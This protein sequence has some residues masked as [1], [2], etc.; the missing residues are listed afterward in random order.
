MP[1]F[2]AIGTLKEDWR[3]RDIDLVEREFAGDVP[4]YWHEN[5]IGIDSFSVDLKEKKTSSDDQGNYWARQEGNG[6]GSAKERRKKREQA[7]Q[8]AGARGVRKTEEVQEEQEQEKLEGYALRIAK[9]SDSVTTEIMN[10]AKNPEPKDI[11]IDCCTTEDNWQYLTLVFRGA[12]P[13]QSTLEDDP[14]DSIVFQW[15]SAIVCAWKFDDANEPIITNVVEFGDDEEVKDASTANQ[16]GLSEFEATPPDVNEGSASGN[17]ARSMYRALSGGLPPVVE[18]SRV[19]DQEHRVLQVDDIDGIE[20]HIESFRGEERISDLYLFDL[21]LRSDK[22]DVVPKD[23]IGKEVKWRLEDDEGI[24]SGEE[25]DPR[26]FHGVI[27]TLLVGELA[28]NTQRRYHVTVVPKVWL[29]TQR[30]D[31]RV[32]QAM[33]AKAI[34]EDVFSRTKFSDYDMAG[35]TQTPPAMEYCVQYQ[36]TDFAF[37]SRL[38]ESAGIS[39][40]FKQEESGSKMMLCD[41]STGYTACP[42]DPIYYAFD[43]YRDPKITAWRR[44]FAFVPGK[45]D[46]RDW[47]FTTPREPVKAESTTS[48]DLTGIKDAEMFVYPGGYPDADVGRTIA[49]RRLLE[50]EMGY[51]FCHAVG[52]YDQMTAGMT[53]VL[54]N[55]PGEDVGQTQKYLITGLRHQAEQFP[56]YGLS[57][58]GYQNVFTCIPEEVPFVPP[59]K[60]PKPVILGPQ[61]AIV[62]GD[63]ETDEEVVDTDKYGRIKVQFHW[64]RHNQKNTDSSCWIRV[65][66][67]LAGSGYGAMAIPRVGWEV[68]V[69]FLNG[70]PDRPLVTGVVYNELHMPAHELKAA[71]H[72]TVLMTRSFPN[73]GK[74]NFNELTFHD[75]KDKE[76]IYFHAEKDFKRV[77]EHEDVLE[78]GEKDDGGQK[79]TIEGDQELTINKGDRT[80]KIVKGKETISVKGDRDTTIESGNEILTVSSGDQTVAVSSGKSELTAGQSIELKVGGSSVKIEAAGITLKVGGSEVKVD[81]MGVTLKGMNV[82]VQAD[83]QAEVKGMMTK[84][85][86]DG[87]LETKGGITMMQ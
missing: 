6:G 63:Q 23:L 56:E 44:H 36:E 35:V 13:A 17:A 81:N 58:V 25:R 1:T 86:G 2:M 49:E 18:E 19:Y 51:D 24:E 41:K 71:K 26:H 5:W 31:S 48:I 59:R 77:V 15:R 33:D 14:S 10:W 50:R 22:L 3:S 11:Q 67:S 42:A 9:P 66:Q 80:K 43:V 52:C 78:V 72:K 62:V 69:S 21:E 27:K 4:T 64:D 54:D 7:D 40:F 20:F 75:E 82:K 84:V 57:V 85:S 83:M 46:S 53:F 29:L 37:V 45:L 39:Y 16:R 60:T 73:G 68:I 12:V 28:S 87:M 55:P 76:E 79:I 32:F 74:D 70:D 30:S 65:A 8:N 61:T 38:M 47:N 34:I